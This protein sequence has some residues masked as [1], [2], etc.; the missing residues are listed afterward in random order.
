MKDFSVGVCS[1][2]KCRLIYLI[3]PLME[4]S[5]SYLQCLYTNFEYTPVSERLW[6]LRKG[7]LRHINSYPKDFH[8]FSF[9]ISF[10]ICGTSKLNNLIL[11]HSD[12]FQKPIFM[13]EY[14]S[15]LKLLRNWL[16]LKIW[17]GLSVFKK[18]VCLYVTLLSN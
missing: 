17:V 18:K 14:L 9:W 1:I 5:W 6:R 3:Q 15:A 8:L 7:V 11:Y 12:I 4:L 2:I 10:V 13:F 16:V